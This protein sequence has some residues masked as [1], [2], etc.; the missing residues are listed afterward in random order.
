MFT[1]FTELFLYFIFKNTFSNAI[2]QTVSLLTIDK[3]LLLRLD[4][5]T[6]IVYWKIGEDI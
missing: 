6:S 4:M 2:D 1:I 5:L 3:N